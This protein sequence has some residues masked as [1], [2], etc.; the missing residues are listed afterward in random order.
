MGSLSK[1]YK[2]IK[3]ISYN[4]ADKNKIIESALEKRKSIKEYREMQEHL[5]EEKNRIFEEELQRQRQ[6]Q[7]NKISKTRKHKKNDKEEGFFERIKNRFTQGRF[8]QG[9]EKSRSKQHSRKSRSK[10]HSR[11][12]RSN[13]K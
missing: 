7:L 6:Y 13:Q 8:T 10:Q 2:S 11:K 5:I 9:T 4:T 12:S 3:S 1:K